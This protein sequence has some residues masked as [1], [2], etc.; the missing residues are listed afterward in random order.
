MSEKKAFPI[1]L[2]K[3]A[4]DLINRQFVRARWEIVPDISIYQTFDECRCSN[5]GAIEYFNKGWKKFNF[6]PNCGARMEQ[7]Q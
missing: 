1:I 4:M 5:C 7:D 2:P 6:C 3:E